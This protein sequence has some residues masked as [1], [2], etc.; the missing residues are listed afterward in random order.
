MEK[1]RGGER[2]IKERCRS[3]EE[4]CFLNI[5]QVENGEKSAG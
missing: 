5:K 1:D 3:E 2:D 4:V